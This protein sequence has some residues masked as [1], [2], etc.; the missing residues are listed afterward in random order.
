M[1]LAISG[2]FIEISTDVTVANNSK[3]FNLLIV[4]TI[5]YS[6]TMTTSMIDFRLALPQPYSTKYRVRQTNVPA[7]APAFQIL[8]DEEN[9]FLNLPVQLHNDKLS[10]SKLKK[11]EEFAA[12]DNTQWARARRSPVLTLR[13][14]TSEIPSLAQIWLIIYAIFSLH[15]EPEQFRVLLEGP[16]PEKLQQDLISVGLAIQNQA[17][18]DASTTALIILRSAFWQGAGSPFGPRP[19]W[20]ADSNNL[21]SSSQPLANYPPQ[22]LTYTFTNRFPTTPIYA[23]H[24]VRSAKP[25]PGS[26]IYSRYI[27]HLKEL[28]SMVALDYKNDEHLQLFHKWQNDPRVAQGWNETGTLDQH[29][30][31]L[32]KLHEDPHVLTVLARF[33]DTFF[34][35]FEIYWAKVYPSHQF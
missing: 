19:V 10:F 27:T 11:G 4:E 16:Q 1:L 34:A 3:F 17:G 31:Y 32:K 18:E 28:F 33:E 14:P 8:L 6:L 35:Y 9:A 13:W 26:T 20:L 22:P 12:N 24:P 23:R 25:T 15:T 30:E 5:Q 21:N 7:S 2:E 29:K